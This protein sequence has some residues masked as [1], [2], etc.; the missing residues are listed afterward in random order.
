M[1]RERSCL[2]LKT[3]SRFSW[4]KQETVART[5]LMAHEEE[6]LVGTWGCPAGSHL[7]HPVCP[8]DFVQWKLHEKSLGHRLVLIV[9]SFSGKPAI[10]SPSPW[11]AAFH[12]WPWP[13][14]PGSSDGTCRDYSW[15][16]VEGV[17][18]EKARGKQTTFF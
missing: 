12:L 9:A 11:V 7:S 16:S 14:S 4:R 6:A 5:A 2:L 3:C 13:R 15:L 1:T 8:E 10:I 17:P 18:F